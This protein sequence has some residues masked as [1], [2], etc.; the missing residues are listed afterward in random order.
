[1]TT[2]GGKRRRR[3]LTNIPLAVA[4]RSTG[5]T[6]RQPVSPDLTATQREVLDALRSVG[7][8]VAG[9]A[10]RPLTGLD[11]YVVRRALADLR[12]LRLASAD[13]RAGVNMWSAT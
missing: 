1:M 9:S 3:A 4:P 8:P 13:Q 12:E 10:L 6:R 7:E 2:V 5:R 11:T